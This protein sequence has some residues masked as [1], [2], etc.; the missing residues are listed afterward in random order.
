ML[1][2]PTK[3]Q[4]D[5]QFTKEDLTVSFAD[6][7]EEYSTLLNSVTRMGAKIACFEHM[8]K[9]LHI[10]KELFLEA[11]F[12]VQGKMLVMSNGNVSRQMGKYQRQ[13]EETDG[14]LYYR[15]R[16]IKFSSRFVQF[17][18][19]SAQLDGHWSVHTKHLFKR[20]S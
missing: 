13:S 15:T 12:A 18:F 10:E 9:K 3:E 14:V 8:D 6:Q 4:A 19:R 17:R 16:T 20:G 11:S 5:V 2:I 1:K 7:F